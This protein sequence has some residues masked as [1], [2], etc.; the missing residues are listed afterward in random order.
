[1]S[2]EGKETRLFSGRRSGPSK[3]FFSISSQGGVT[4]LS[5]AAP[6]AAPP[7]M[8]LAGED[9]D[10][11]SENGPFFLSKDQNSSG[12]MAP[13]MAMHNCGVM[14]TYLRMSHAS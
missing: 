2:V 7:R 14:R 9:W 10:D 11:V 13:A 6:P 8:G 1:M 3:A 4:Y 12:F 5:T